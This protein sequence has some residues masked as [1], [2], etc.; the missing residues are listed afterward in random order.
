[1][2]REEAGRRDGSGSYEYSYQA[3]ISDE[4]QREEAGEP[5]PE[6]E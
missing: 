6:K 5:C 2:G 3:S 4:G 1:M